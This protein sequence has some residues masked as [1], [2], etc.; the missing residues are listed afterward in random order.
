MGDF[1]LD[2]LFPE[3]FFDG[4]ADVHLE[5]ESFGLDDVGFEGQ[6]E[7]G[8]QVFAIAGDDGC[9]LLEEGSQDGVGQGDGGVVE[10]EDTDVFTGDL[11][12]GLFVLVDKQLSEVDRQMRPCRGDFHDPLDHTAPFVLQG[13]YRPTRGQSLAGKMRP[14][15]S[16]ATL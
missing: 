10:Q 4:R 5:S 14:R 7:A 12:S 13:L 11:S 9:S 2:N 15:G 8:G 3:A 6:E 16:T 1:G